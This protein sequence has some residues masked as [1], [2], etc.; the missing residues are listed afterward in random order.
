MCR[1]SDRERRRRS[2]RDSL[3]FRREV[4]WTNFLCLSCYKIFAYEKHEQ[5]VMSFEYD[6]INI[7]SILRIRLENELWCSQSYY[8]YSCCKSNYLKGCKNFKRISMLR[9]IYKD[10]ILYVTWKPEVWIRY[11]ASLKFSLAR[12]WPSLIFLVIDIN[13]F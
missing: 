13:Y 9:S 11:K 10:V 3:E 1:G 5:C 4:F 12:L 6:H 2:L 7:V 8:L